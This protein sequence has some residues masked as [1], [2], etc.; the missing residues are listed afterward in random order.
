MIKLGDKV[1]DSITG[2]IGI[3]T[4][5]CVYLNGCNHIGFQLPFKDGKIPD[6]IWIDEPQVEVVKILKKK[7]KTYTGGPKQ[8]PPRR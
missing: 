3:A 2:V 5:K 6:I 1:K 7:R 4:A 8:H